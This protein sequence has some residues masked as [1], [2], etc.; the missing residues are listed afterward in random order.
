MALMQIAVIPLGT[1]TPGVGDYIVDIERFLLARGTKHVLH[2]MG[3]II[4]GRPEELL[5]LAAEIHNLPF[6][7]G[8]ERVVTQI[9]LDDRRDIE[10]EIGEKK[11]SV[12]NK[13]R[14][15]VNHEE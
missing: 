11:D 12:I 5:V 8:A 9:T 3:T 14:E 10:R 1:P 2:D 4:H 15:P 13:L 7:R 6:V